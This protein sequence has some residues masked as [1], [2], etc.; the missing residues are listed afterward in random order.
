MKV[1]TLWIPREVVVP[2]GG[3]GGGWETLVCVIDLVEV[4]LSVGEKLNI[5]KPDSSDS[6]RY[7]HFTSNYSSLAGISFYQLDPLIE[8]VER[9]LHGT[10]R[11]TIV[12]DLIG[13]IGKPLVA[14]GLF[15][16]GNLCIDNSW[17]KKIIICPQAWFKP[18]KCWTVIC[19]VVVVGHSASPVV[20]IA[21]ALRILVDASHVVL[22]NLQQ[23]LTFCGLGL[24]PARDEAWFLY[25][26]IDDHDYNDLLTIAETHFGIIRSRYR[27]IVDNYS[28]KR[29][30]C[31]RLMI[32]WKDG[33]RLSELFRSFVL[34][35]TSCAK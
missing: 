24:H 26:I 23:S 27:S 28:G 9:E 15:E 29:E 12:D 33:S 6:N 17:L 16:T 34:Y 7:W 30:Q 31:Y 32:E 10:K 4:P 13:E 20:F 21:P 11:L 22:G 18:T 25:N 19:N 14:T 8:A 35:I 5:F 2:P 3:G 1:S